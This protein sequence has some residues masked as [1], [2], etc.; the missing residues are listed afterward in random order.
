M[1]ERSNHQFSEMAYALT[2]I[3]SITFVISA[4]VAVG[5][6]SQTALEPP[7]LIL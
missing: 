1:K 2:L 5:S 4:E 3:A 6:T 7:L